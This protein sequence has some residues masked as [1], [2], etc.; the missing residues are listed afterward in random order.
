M[1]LR[2]AIWCPDGRARLPLAASLCREQLPADLIVWSSDEATPSAPVVGL[3]PDLWLVLCAGDPPVPPAW[4][5]SATGVWAVFP[6]SA[7]RWTGATRAATE[8]WR[9]DSILTDLL[10]DEGC[11]AVW[12]A[13]WP[14]R[15]FLW[16][17]AWGRVAREA[18]RTSLVV[19][20]DV[21]F[22]E[23]IVD[24]VL[25]VL[26]SV[27]GGQVVQLDSAGDRG[28]Q[29]AALVGRAD[30]VLLCSLDPVLS[31]IAGRMAKPLG[32]ALYVWG[33][34]PSWWRA[35]LLGSP[36]QKAWNL[37]FPQ[38][39]LLSIVREISASIQAA[40]R[41]SVS[42]TGGP[43][44]NG[45]LA[46]LT[47]QAA[48][49]SEGWV[50]G[51]LVPAL[52]R[53]RKH[54]E[55]PALAEEWLRLVP[56]WRFDIFAAIT[57]PSASYIEPVGNLLRWFMALPASLETGAFLRRLAQVVPQWPSRLL[58]YTDAAQMGAVAQWLFT[59]V[60]DEHVLGQRKQ[61]V[62]AAAEGYRRALQRSPEDPLLIAKVATTAAMFGDFAAADIQ[63]AELRG[64]CPHRIHGVLASVMRAWNAE[65]EVGI[66]GVVPTGG[67]R[68]WQAAADEL[69]RREGGEMCYFAAQGAGRF[70]DAA[71]ADERLQRVSPSPVQVAGAGTVAWLMGDT[72][73]AERLWG[74]IEH[75]DWPAAGWGRFAMLY[76]SVFLGEGARQ[77]TAE[78]AAID[79]GSPGLFAPSTPSHPR[80]ALRAMLHRRLGDEEAAQAWWTRALAEDPLAVLRSPAFER[81]RP[82]SLGT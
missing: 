37:E 10:P 60:A 41:R 31:G 14:E 34:F 67:A 16:L 46:A 4:R 20:I 69:A 5:E 66:H 44:W 12:S 75:A 68:W 6:G 24:P 43:G 70:G 78:L 26:A 45:W 40:L 32:T 53:L 79:A 48:E 71:G 73:R 52:A 35:Q 39:R 80:C 77:F 30:C 19:A 13:W 38:E 82:P 72:V 29:I 62:E 33:N 81:A 9:P 57:L 61:L 47:G 74:S 8:A 15:E 55:T 64:R 56:G 51:M 2:I 17:P 59:Q 50:A 49:R 28:G 58:E 42:P 76:A 22:P 65:L 7:M 23:W 27:H 36:V 3:N 21:G 11:S 63:L 18:K 25:I 54:P 1:K